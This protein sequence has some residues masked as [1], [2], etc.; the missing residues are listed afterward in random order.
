MIKK[1]IRGHATRGKEVIAELEKLGGANSNYCEGTVEN[2][3]YIIHPKNN[4]IIGFWDDSIDGE[5]IKECFEEI[6]LPTLQTPPPL[7]KTWGEYMATEDF[8]NDTPTLDF[9]EFT[10]L[11]E[12]FDETVF[13][14]LTKLIILRD[15]YRQGWLPE[16][17]YDK[18]D[19]YS[20]AICSFCGKIG[21][22]D[23]YGFDYLL[24]FQSEKI[25]DEFYDNFID[26]IEK[27]K[28]FI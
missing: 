3:V 2:C 5:I 16:S 18:N 25:R 17:E 20:Y 19:V 7:P 12:K 11:I 8:S 6:K 4:K 27:A 26:L 21:K 9:L 24:S 22:V 10:G 23:T 1:Y 15:Y 28:E 13:H 14:A